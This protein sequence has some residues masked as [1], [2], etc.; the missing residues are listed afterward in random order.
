MFNANM[1]CGQSTIAEVRECARQTYN[2][3]KLINEID[4]IEQNVIVKQASEV[5]S[6]LIE[7]H[8][9]NN[10]ILKM[11]CEG[12][13]YGIIEDLHDKNL[14]SLFSFIMMEWHYRGN[15]ELLQT[16]KNAGFSYWCS[17][18]ARNMGLIYA[19]KNC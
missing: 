1:S 19:F 15:E 17:N 18:K 7:K 8:R 6:P 10:L 2:Q 16:L 12:E 11:D 14:L 5:F 4:E 13:E 3:L 9:D